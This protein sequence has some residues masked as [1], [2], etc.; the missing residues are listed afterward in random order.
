MEILNFINRVGIEFCIFL[1]EL[2]EEIQ[3]RENFS[4]SKIIF[5]NDKSDIC[6]IINGKTNKNDYVLVK[7]SRYWRLEEIIPFIY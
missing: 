6:Q 3:I 2:K 7:G 1:C 5:K 4:S